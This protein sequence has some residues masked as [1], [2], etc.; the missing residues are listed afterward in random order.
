M[1]KAVAY[2]LI[3]GLFFAAMNVLVKALPG[4]ST[5]EVILFRAAVSLIISYISIRKRGLNPFGNEK[6]LLILRGLFGFISLSLF[7]LTLQKMPLAS[8]VSMQYLAPIFTAV[9]AIYINKQHTAPFT[10]LFYCVS[11]SGV[12][13]IK[14][15]DPRIDNWMLLAGIGSAFL[16]GAAYNMI[17][18]TGKK[19]DPY[20][21]VF[22]FPLVTFPLA[23]VPAILNWKTPTEL[24]DW[25]LLIG[26]G[27]TTQFGQVFMTKAFQDAKLSGVAIF[28]YI[29]LI[30]A[31]ILGITFFG[32]TF[33]WKAYLGMGLVVAG[34]VAN[35]IYEKRM[36]LQE[37]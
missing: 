11:F 7:F 34:A 9:L 35:A 4:Y 33:D 22:Y 10:W 19:D 6:K 27:V 3:S 29:G 1:N 26:V 5:Y 21:I 15:F 30:Y 16:S 25:L 12:L 32:E 37:E 24:T 13:F 8:A 23:L 18:L 20:V 2:I 36:R 28:Q 14:G 31:I 17:R